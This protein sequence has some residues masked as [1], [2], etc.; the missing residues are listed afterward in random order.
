MAA[1]GG[2]GE[3]VMFGAR[4]MKS[5]VLGLGALLLAGCGDRVGRAAASGVDHPPRRVVYLVATDSDRERGRTDF[6]QFTA[7][8][9]RTLGTDMANVLLE[10][11]NAVGPGS[12]PAAGARV[13]VPGWPP[14]R[15]QVLSFG[16]C[17]L[18]TTGA[19]G[20]TVSR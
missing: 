14:P 6:L 9:R 11:V 13:K 5:V 20:A 15:C 4:T 17:A 3:A 19:P 10:L 8:V 12:E 1:A 7:A 18:V 16:Y 2:G